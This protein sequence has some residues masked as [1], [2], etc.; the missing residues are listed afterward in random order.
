MFVSSDIRKRTVLRNSAV[1]SF[2]QRLHYMQYYFAH[3]FSGWS[4]NIQINRM[5]T[6]FK[7]HSPAIALIWKCRFILSW[8]TGLFG[9]FVF[10]TC[11]VLQCLCL[12]FFYSKLN[13]AFQPPTLCGLYNTRKIVEKESERSNHLEQCGFFSEKFRKHWTAE[14]KKDW[15]ELKVQ[16]LYGSCNFMQILKL[17]S[18]NG[19]HFHEFKQFT[20]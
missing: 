4:I 14:L 6:I 19:N 17:F 11:L 15:V 13:C 1:F 9:W 8:I 3:F 2:S 5:L 20:E 7:F 12:V 10:S 18:V 16:L